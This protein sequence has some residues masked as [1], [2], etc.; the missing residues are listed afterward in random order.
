MNTTLQTNKLTDHR[1]LVNWW[2]RFE[3]L[4]WPSPDNVDRVKMRAE[5]MAEANITTAILFGAHFR[6]D[7]LP[8]FTLLHD[9]IATIAEE[10]H[11]YG[12]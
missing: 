3:D 2:M 4:N 6:C 10:L 9:H 1:R 5:K 7:Y 8:Y 11:K 12:I